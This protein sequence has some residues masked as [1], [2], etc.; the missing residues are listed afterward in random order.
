MLKIFRRV[1]VLQ[2]YFNMKIL[3]QSWEEHTEK[4]TAM[5]KFFPKE[6]AF[7]ATTYIKQYGRQRLERCWCARAQKPF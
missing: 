4:A 1:N 6:I 3:Q 2:K 7:A 5:E